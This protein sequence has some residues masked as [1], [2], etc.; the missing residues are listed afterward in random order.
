MQIIS[1]KY[2]GLFKRGLWLTAAALM[3]F[4]ASPR[5]FDGSLWRDPAPSL[6]APAI[7]GAFLLYFLAKMQILRL[8]DEVMDCSD[9]L[10]V[11][12]GRTELAIPIS[13]IAS[14]EVSTFSGIH[15]I[16]VYLREPAMFGARLEFLPQASL[17]SD[18]PALKRLAQGLAE[19]AN[20]LKGPTNQPRE[21]FS[22][23]HASNLK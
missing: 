16:C 7:L 23:R 9:H 6:I 11:R 22:H 10:K 13:N 18:L 1:F 2:T 21:V 20:S 14:A 17:W 8:A 12:R 4:V 15:R 5:V 3:A 19:R